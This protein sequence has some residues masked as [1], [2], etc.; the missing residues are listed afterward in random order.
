MNAKKKTGFTYIDCC[1][2]PRA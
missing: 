2:W 1:Y